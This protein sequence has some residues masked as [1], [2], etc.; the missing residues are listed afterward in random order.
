MCSAVV[1]AA[2]KVDLQRADTKGEG[3]DLAIKHKLNYIEVSALTGKG[4]EELV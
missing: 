4:I 3:F 1:L 2:N